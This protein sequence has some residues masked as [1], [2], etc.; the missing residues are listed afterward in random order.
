MAR[1]ATLCQPIARSVYATGE[2]HTWYAAPS[3]AHSK[4]TGEAFEEK[5][6]DADVSV[7]VS[8]GPETIVVCGGGTIVH[9]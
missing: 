7:V 5:L 4:L 8:G 6:M 1:T 9:V 3:S 2:V